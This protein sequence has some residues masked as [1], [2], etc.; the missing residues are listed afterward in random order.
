MGGRPLLCL[1]AC[2][3]VRPC[4][5]TCRGYGL[6]LCSRAVL[7]EEFEDEFVM[8]DVC[9]KSERSF[10]RIYFRVPSPNGQGFVYCYQIQWADGSCRTVYGVPQKLAMKACSW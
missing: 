2:V 3:C 8:P 7:E 6:L 10:E 4:V 5:C 1:R 9:S